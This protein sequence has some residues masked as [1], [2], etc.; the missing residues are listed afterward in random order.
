MN[1]SADLGPGEGSCAQPPAPAAL[2]ACTAGCHRVTSATIRSAGAGPARAWGLACLSRDPHTRRGSRVPEHRGRRTGQPHPG[3]QWRTRCCLSRL[4][5]L[6]VSDPWLCCGRGRSRDAVLPGRELL[7]RWAAWLGGGA[8]AAPGPSS[9]HGAERLLAGGSHCMVGA[10]EGLPGGGSPRASQVSKVPLGTGWGAS[11][12]EM[13]L[14]P[15]SPLRR[16][17]RGE[18]HFRLTGT[19][20]PTQLSFPKTG[21]PSPQGRRLPLPPHSCL[22]AA[23]RGRFKHKP[24]PVLPAPAPDGLPSPRN[25]AQASSPASAPG[26]RLPASPA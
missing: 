14:I 12:G 7:V 18:G 19:A 10:Q 24:E 6:T 20:C 15:A 16:P 23:A 26:T 11:D 13:G 25:A 22:H 5:L 2:T 9:G 17:C 4:T 3:P 8:A 21:R 1:P